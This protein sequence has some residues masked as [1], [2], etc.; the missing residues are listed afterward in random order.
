MMLR[1]LQCHL[2][3]SNGTSTVP[4]MLCMFDSMETLFNS[5]DHPGTRHTDSHRFLCPYL[6]VP[7]PCSSRSCL[8]TS[9]SLTLDHHLGYVF[10]LLSNSAS[11]LYVVADTVRTPQ[12]YL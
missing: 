7:L 6:E 8:L 9:Q 4:T 1:Q 12:L 5:M 2:D 10:P 11:M 3:H